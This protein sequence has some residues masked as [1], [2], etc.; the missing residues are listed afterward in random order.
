MIPTSVTEPRCN[1]PNPLSSPFQSDCRVG[2]GVTRVVDRGHGY[3]EGSQEGSWDWRSGVFRQSGFPCVWASSGSTAT[4]SPPFPGPT[5]TNGPSGKLILTSRVVPSSPGVS[6][7]P[8]LGVGRHSP[9]GPC[10]S[11]SG[12]RRPSPLSMVLGFLPWVISSG[13][14]VSLSVRVTWGPGRYV[15]PGGVGPT[16]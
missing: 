6:S 4:L 14:W 10:R 12:V 16:H 2:P 3:L 1:T 8:G 15:G 7:S 11:V 9:R 5:S 13:S